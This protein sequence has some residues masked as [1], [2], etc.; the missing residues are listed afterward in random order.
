MK[1]EYQIRTIAPFRN[2]RE[3]IERSVVAYKFKTSMC[4]DIGES[5]TCPRGESCTFAH[6][7]EEMERYRARSRLMGYRSNVIKP[8]GAM[9]GNGDG[10]Q[11][12]GRCVWNSW[13][14][15]ER[16]HEGLFLF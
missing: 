2:Q 5:K 10:G 7:L 4:R 16:D 1:W 8:R 3:S 9:D 12:D 15:V 14:L 13:G 6:S 11:A